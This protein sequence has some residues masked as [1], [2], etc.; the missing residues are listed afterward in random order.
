MQ[1]YCSECKRK[2]YHEGVIVPYELKSSVYDELQWIEKY[3]IVKCG[4]CKTVA[5]VKQYGDEDMWEETPW[6]DR[7]YTHIYTV[8]PEEP[9]HKQEQHVAKKFIKVP[10]FIEDLY[11]EVVGAYNNNSMILCSIGLRMIIEA[12]C[13]DKGISNIPLTNQDGTPKRDDV[14]GE[15]KY[16]FLGLAEK[17]N[18]LLSNGYITQVQYQVLQQI[19]DLGNETAHEITRHSDL[20]IKEALGVLENMLYNI[21]DLASIEIFKK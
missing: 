9:I 16:R 19:K 8:Y 5:F 7:E 6:G 18:T 17:L 21:F 4:G 11:I 13:K 12:I 15:Y 1:V 14:T 20:I 10:A 2:T 3:H